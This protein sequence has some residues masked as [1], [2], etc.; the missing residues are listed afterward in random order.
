MASLA[1]LHDG[2]M[3]FE[4]VV[5]KSVDRDELNVSNIRTGGFAK[6]AIHEYVHAST[7]WNDRLAVVASLRDRHR[8]E[9][10]QF[11]LSL[12]RRV[13]VTHAI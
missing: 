2:A 4:V 8:G 7:N 11:S 3:A 1:E 5:G 9:W 13:I 6:E 12:F 10:I